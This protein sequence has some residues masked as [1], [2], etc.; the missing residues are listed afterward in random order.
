MPPLP[1]PVLVVEDDAE[2]RTMLATVLTLE[3]FRVVTAQDGAEALRLAVED[4]PCVILLDL[5]MPVM[6]GEQFRARQLADP[7]IAGLPV[8][9]V[10]AASGAEAKAR[11][12]G[13]DCCIRKPIN[14]DELNAQIAPYCAVAARGKAGV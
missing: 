7:R 1:R 12:L 11:E 13:I 9:L 5:M 2:S 10:S 8:I 14:L 4:Q 3:G 6:D